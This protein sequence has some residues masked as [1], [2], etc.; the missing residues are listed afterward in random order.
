MEGFVGPQ[1]VADFG[2]MLTNRVCGVFEGAMIRR[3][4]G[5]SAVAKRGFAMSEM[6]TATEFMQV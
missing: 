4:L 1:V 5:Q 3:S 2:V 6:F